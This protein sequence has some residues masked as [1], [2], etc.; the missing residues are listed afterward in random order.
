MASKASKWH[1]RVERGADRCAVRGCRSPGEYRAPLSPPTFDG[2]GTWQYLC[3]DHVRAHNAAYDYFAGM[4]PDEIMAAQS[5]I[6]GWERRVRAFAHVG[7]D[8]VPA[9]A[10]F[11]DP[12]DA[13]SARFR[14]GRP[15]RPLDVFTPRE[16]EA[17]GVLGLGEG[18]DL[19]AVRRR[20]SQLVRRFHPDRNG[21]DR[22]HEARLAAVIDAWQLL[23]RARA[24]A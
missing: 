14:P 13:I 3:L 18:C 6:A 20:Y 10:D 19:H 1:G 11:A 12:L 24:F 15:R 9:W 22:R 2:P 5:P 8:A 21:G 4:S 23:R 17:L 7:A 16:R